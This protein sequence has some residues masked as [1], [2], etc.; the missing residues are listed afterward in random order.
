[1]TK[2]CKNSHP[3]GIPSKTVIALG[4][5]VLCYILLTV[6]YSLVNNIKLKLYG[7]EGKAVVTKVIKYEET[8][9]AINYEYKVDGIIYV[10][11]SV[12]I[13]EE[14]VVG[15]SICISYLP[16]NPVISIVLD[17]E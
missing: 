1:M 11:K 14:K 15:D 16:N 2:H 5:G 12:L 17:D 4:G 8:N 13:S 7:K 6:G 10:N 3:K 9:S